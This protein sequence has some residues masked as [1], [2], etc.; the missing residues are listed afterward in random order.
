M[1]TNYDDREVN[2]EIVERIGVLATFD[3]GW[4]KELNL[5]SWN[6]GAPKYDIRDWA[7]SHKHM[8]RGITL[9]EKEMRLMIDLLKRRRFPR[10]DESDES[11]QR[12]VNSNEECSFDSGYN[13]VVDINTEV[14]ANTEF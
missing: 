10:S 9:H 8:S 2:F 11:D 4:A 14:A 7:P 13:S 12:E 6:G 1:A 5:V 3:T